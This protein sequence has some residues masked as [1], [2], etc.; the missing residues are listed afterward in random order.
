MWRGDARDGAVWRGAAQDS[1]EEREAAW[2]S[3]G[4]LETAALWSDKQNHFAQTSQTQK[5]PGCTFCK[6]TNRDVISYNV[7]LL[8]S[9]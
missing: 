1:T 5:H 3:T 9:V 7:S 4:G 6:G 2:D 8:A